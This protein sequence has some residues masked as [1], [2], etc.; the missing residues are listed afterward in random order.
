[1]IRLFLFLPALLAAVVAR[2]V[3]AQDD[4]PL[5]ALDLWSKQYFGGK[6][7]LTKQSS[8]S[9]TSPGFRTKVL[10][11]ELA[12]YF[13]HFD[14][15][16]AICKQVHTRGG[17][18]AG[19]LLLQLAA[20][21]LD[22]D[23]R[24]GPEEFP[25]LIRV[26]AEA[27]LDRLDPDTFAP[28]IDIALS[29]ASKGHKAAE[30]AAAIRAVGRRKDVKLNEVVLGA[31]EEKEDMLRLAAVEAVFQASAPIEKDALDRWFDTV[32]NS[33]TVNPGVNRARSDM[34]GLL[35]IT[36]DDWLPPRVGTEANEARQAELLNSVLPALGKFIVKEEAG[37]PLARALEAV[38][39]IFDRYHNELNETHFKALSNAARGAIGRAGWR[40]DLQATEVLVRLRSAESVPILIELLARWDEDSRA[41]VEDKSGTLRR[42]AHEVLKSLTGAPYG[43]DASDRWLSWW[44]Q[45]RAEFKV[46]ELK[47]EGSVPDDERTVTG[48]FFGIEVRG[49]RILFVIDTSGSMAS[50]LENTVQGSAG[51]LTRGTVKMEVAK[52]ELL[53]VVDQLTTDS[54]FNV[55]RFSNDAELWKK[56]MVKAEPKTKARFVKWAEKL[57]PDGGTNLWQGL[58]DGLQYQSQSVGDYYG[59]NYD[60]V[61]ILSDGIPSV[62]DVTDP[63]Q[64][65]RLVAETNRW[66]RLRI[67]TI[68]ISATEE[69][70]RQVKAALGMS[71]EE[72][73]RRLA[74]ENG[75]EAVAF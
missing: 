74:E 3:A 75:G 45:V 69:E 38:S 52:R 36:G 34:Q 26:T 5:L 32:S 27:W 30:R 61:F 66:A 54:W 59:V 50:P 60:E 16:T 24:Y 70:E 68:Y 2:P 58:V 4:R 15:L 21:G 39:V 65:L 56:K 49:S 33:G 10:P 71:G 6:L 48:S 13:S 1:M 55:V 17:E 28:V 51:E 67:N 53:S 64:I 12:K 14:E 72:F 29:D 37:P 8:I 11:D 46:A 62:G 43:I 73:M 42:R 23:A 25:N 18:R 40:A 47:E 20:V 22:P 44:E 31:I 7:D 35:K 41:E 19:E 57:R 9:K 63:E